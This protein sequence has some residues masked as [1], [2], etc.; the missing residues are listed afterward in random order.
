MTKGSKSSGKSSSSTTPAGKASEAGKFGAT[1][2]KVNVGPKHVFFHGQ[3]IALEARVNNPVSKAH[4]PKHFGK[5]T[6]IMQVRQVEHAP[7][8][9]NEHAGEKMK[10]AAAAQDPAQTK[11]LQGGDAERVGVKTD[12]Q[13]AARM[14][15]AGVKDPGAAM[16]A[17]LQVEMEHT[18]NADV[19][20]R[21]RRD[22][23][24]NDPN[25]Y[26]RLAKMEK[27]GDASPEGKAMQAAVK[28]ETPKFDRR[29][30]YL[31]TIAKR[32]FKEL[33]DE[34]GER[35]YRVGP[36][37][38]KNDRAF[39]DTEAEIAR[40]QMRAYERFIKDEGKTLP[41][42]DEKA[43]E[44][45]TFAEEGERAVR[46]AELFR[47]SKA[48]EERHAARIDPKNKAALASL[49][50]RANA[51]FAITAGFHGTPN[52]AA[53]RPIHERIFKALSD[54]K[55]AVQ[56]KQRAKFNIATD[57]L[58][59]AIKDAQEMM[60]RENRGIRDEFERQRDVILPGR[61]DATEKLEK[62]RAVANEIGMTAEKFKGRAMEINSRADFTATL[63]NAITRA[64]AVNKYGGEVP[65]YAIRESMEKAGYS[66][67]DLLTRVQKL[68]D[69]RLVDL[70][71]VNDPKAFNHP[72]STF[73]A[74]DRTVGYIA[75]RPEFE[76]VTHPVTW[77]IDAK[78]GSIESP[79]PAVK[80]EPYHADWLDVKGGSITKA[81][82]EKQ[83]AGHTRKDTAPRVTME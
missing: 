78:G 26:D 7:A 28:G 58:V 66:W 21:I 73:K 82:K 79:K 6:S 42:V 29:R 75:L 39:S 55:S 54:V 81:A 19:A 4:V 12:K 76:K 24:V 38:V 57:E 61:P 31:V 3:G 27:A 40:R 63:E 68:Q 14:K 18:R 62:L 45:A 77:F 48:F 13:L 83:A 53:A 37:A 70:H 11:L 33:N 74:G 80:E 71:V 30:S 1:K 22:H 67:P 17:G 10:M 65:L 47:E 32:R 25:Y 41:K 64:D 5:R 8:P 56:Y 49:E 59:A 34:V 23:L 72:E 69:D 2:S 16:R 60:I 15:A 51:A 50:Q 43:I 35:G 9:G 52:E 20:K 36:E 46:R 44:N